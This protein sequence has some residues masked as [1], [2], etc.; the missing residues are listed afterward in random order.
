MGL[1]YTTF[2]TFLYSLKYVKNYGSLLTLG[3]QFMYHIDDRIKNIPQKYNFSLSNSCFKLETEDLLKEIGFQN[4]DSLDNSK[5]E[6]AT[7]ISD[8]NKPVDINKKYNLIFDGGCTEHIY[9]IPQ[10]FNNVIKLLQI[11]GIYVGITVNN[12]FSG[13]GFYQF[14]PEFFLST[15]SQKYGMELLELFLIVNGDDFNNKLDVKSYENYRNTNMINTTQQ[16]YILI[17]ARKISE[18]RLNLVDN[19]PFQY[20]YEMVD[21]KS[22][23]TI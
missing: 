20:N 5:Y 21:W 6:N 10:V 3:R 8:L 2:E 12:N 15:F 17:I 14:S 23:L 11:G 7:I 22:N 13:H 16:T 18:S 9:N 1:D 4:I 19:P